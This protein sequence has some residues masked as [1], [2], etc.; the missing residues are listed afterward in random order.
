[1]TVLRA[2][3]A[4]LWVAFSLTATAHAG[5][6][7]ASEPACHMAT[8]EMANMPKAPKPHHTE[9]NTMPCCSQPVIIAPAYTP[10]P[11][12]AAAPTARL[13]PAPALPL[14]GTLVP[15]DPHPPKLG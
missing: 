8:T 1:M 14:A 3:L 5:R 12:A 6:M 9:Q 10:L 4:L 15:Y 11:I 7:T 2:M 13:S